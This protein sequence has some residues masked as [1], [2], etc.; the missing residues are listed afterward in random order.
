MHV[1]MQTMRIRVS[2]YTY[3]FVC[4]H[5]FVYVC[6]VQEC[7][8]LCIRICMC[9]QTNMYILCVVCLL[10]KGS[11]SPEFYSHLASFALNFVQCV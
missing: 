11:N 7:V 9:E 3:M 1:D 6:D 5:M 2:M 8:Y 4:V 10:C